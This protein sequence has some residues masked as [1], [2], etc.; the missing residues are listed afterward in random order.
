M[1]TGRELSSP[2]SG[3][4]IASIPPKSA[5]TTLGF[6]S[7]QQFGCRYRRATLFKHRPRITGNLDIPCKLCLDKDPGKG[8]EEKR[9]PSGKSYPNMAAASLAATALP[10]L[11]LLQ[12][13][14][15]GLQRITI[16]APKGLCDP[17][18]SADGHSAIEPEFAFLLAASF[19]QVISCAQLAKPI[20]DVFKLVARRHVAGG[21]CREGRIL[22]MPRNGGVV[23]R[24]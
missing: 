13:L 1:R 8:G 19:K 17:G 16:E 4:G 9:W 21:F 2:S 15:H 5:A 12:D 14:S 10:I 20:L 23:Q 3:W 11:D 7:S 24:K 6:R 18:V 22:G